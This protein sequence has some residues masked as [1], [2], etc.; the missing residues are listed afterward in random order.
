MFADKI[1]APV[2]ALIVSLVAALP[3]SSP[4]AREILANV[5]EAYATLRTYDFK[6]SN[7]ATYELDGIKYGMTIPGELA[8]GDNADE[9]LTIRTDIFRVRKLDGSGEYVV[10]EPGLFYF[11]DTSYYEF[12]RIGHDIEYAKLLREETAEANGKSV[13]CF[14]VELLKIPDPFAS[15]HAPPPRPQTL[16][17]DKSTFLVLREV[18][19]TV[20]PAHAGHPTFMIEWD[21][22]FPSYTLNAPSPPWLVDSKKAH[23]EQM[24]QLSAKMV[25]TRAPDFKLRDME[26]HDVSLDDLRDKVVLIDFWATWCGPCRNELPVLASLERAWNSKG[27][28]VIRITSEPPEDVQFF[29]QKTGQPVPTLVNG[30]DVWKQYNVGGIPTL[31]LIDKTGKIAAYDAS[32]LS[33]AEIITRL[34][35]VGLN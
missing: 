12:A 7:T 24:A 10:P 33:A 16:W 20:I 17:V 18:F 26:G 2:A 29:V 6:L 28:V 21:V 35:K 32:F 22:T 23:A 8:Q 25:G 11:P 19:Q 3:A 4:D 34:A 15:A 14:V 13:P 30:Q 9:P 1:I 27:L 31:V 5:R